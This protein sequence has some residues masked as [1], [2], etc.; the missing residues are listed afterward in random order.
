[1]NLAQFL[2]W[3]L[4]QPIGAFQPVEVHRFV[5]SGG[6]VTSLVLYRKPP[7]QVE[8]FILDPDCGSFPEHSHPNVDSIEFFLCGDIAFTRDGKE[9]YPSTDGVF[10]TKIRVR[11]GQPHGAVRASGA[12]YSV[13][14][15]TVD[16]SS[17]GLDWNGPK[18]VSA[19]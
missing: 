14:K 4:E 17:V 3:F 19:A 7:F 6:G 13:Q 9:L 15:W 11:A 16:P 10:G 12:F 1:M 8:L 5:T 2:R 18:H